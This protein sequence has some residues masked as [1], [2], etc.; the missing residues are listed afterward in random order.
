MKKILFLF[1]ATSFL[2]GCQDDCLNSGHA[3]P[4]FE[5]G[6]EVRFKSSAYGKTAVIVDVEQSGRTN[7][8]PLYTVSYFTLWDTRRIKTVSEYEIEKK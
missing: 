3:G 7:C 5:K 1:I 4:K 8:E 2:L 6:E